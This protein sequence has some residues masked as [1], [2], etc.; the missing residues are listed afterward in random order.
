MYCIKQDDYDDFK[1]IAGACPKSCC[2]GWQIVIDEDSLKYYKKYKGEFKDRLEAGIDFKEGVYRQCGGRCAMLNKDNLCDE[3]LALGEEHLC[4][5]CGMYPRHI[6]EYDGRN[7]YSLSLSCPEAARMT[8]E[9]KKPVDFSDFEDDEEGEEIE[10]YDYLLDTKLEDS[11][12][13]IYKI[14]R[15]RELP[16][17]I[18][19][20]LIRKFAGKLQECLDD[21]ALFDM[22]DVI[23]EWDSKTFS[24][25]YFKTADIS[26][27]FELE[28]LEAD[29][30]DTLDAAFSYVKKAGAINILKTMEKWEEN[31]L[32]NALILLIYTYYCGAVYDDMIYSKVCL[33][34]YS[35]EWIYEIYRSR[36][37]KENITGEEEKKQALIKSIYLYAREVEHSD[38]NLNALED[39]FDETFV[40][41]D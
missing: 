23:E 30:D 19:M 14:I 34:I 4:Y 22:D 32:E 24:E 12:D 41:E 13:V 27:L 11:R 26:K 18:R 25:D 29:W 5:T 20:E 40:R 15:N 2:I 31:A 37:E 8:V 17:F 6:E 21:D 36:L 1:C 3:Q 35:I 38:L 33:S 28:K 9:R 7:E 10:D 39:W 16:L